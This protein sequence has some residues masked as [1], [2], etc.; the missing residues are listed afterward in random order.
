MKRGLIFLAAIV[1]VCGLVC[2]PVSAQVASPPT[3]SAAFDRDTVMIGDRFYLD[4]TVEK[5]VMQVVDFPVLA[6]GEIAPD[7]EVLAEEQPTVVAEDGRR[8]TLSKR[9]VMTIFREG[10]HRPGRMPVLYLDK[11]LVD[12]LYSRDTLQVAVSTFEIDLEKD[13]PLDIKPLRRIPLRFGEIGGWFA[14]GLGII[15]LLVVGVLLL[16]KYRHRIPLLGGER[17][18]VP[19]HIEAI[20]KLEALRN[21]KLPQNG[22]HKQYW[23][24]LADILREY[25]DGR[26]GIGALEM[27]TDE[28]LAALDAP[29]REGVVDAKRYENL[30]EL[31]R[32]ADLVKFA[33]YTPD[34]DTTDGAYYNAYYFV[35]ETK[36]VADDGK[37]EEKEL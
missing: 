10:V 8:H 3:V 19:P 17:P 29:R 5:D 25:L 28:T 11:N 9:Y 24:G 33:K 15:A 16:T 20:R 37:A 12:T 34:E 30:A 26:F 21:Q 32:T 13:K 1:S 31:L 22:R 14:L 36:V 4:V 35:E 27:T 18:K 6:G 7:V 23:S 2:G